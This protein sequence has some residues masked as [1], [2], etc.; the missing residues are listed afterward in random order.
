MSDLS[1]KNGDEDSVKSP[2]VGGQAGS[3]GTGAGTGSAGDAGS[4]KASGPGKGSETLESLKAKE[5]RVEKETLKNSRDVNRVKDELRKEKQFNSYSSWLGVINFALLIMLILGIYIYESS[6]SAR[7]KARL[8]DIKTGV[9]RLED[10]VQSLGEADKVTAISIQNIA[11]QAQEHDDRLAESDRKMVRIQGRVDALAGKLDS[12]QPAEERKVVKVMPPEKLLINEVRYLLKLSYRKMYLEH[13]ISVAVS[14]LRDADLLLAEMDDPEILPV[15]KGIAA[16]I[17]KLS[18]LEP[19][20]SESLVIRIAALEENVRSMPVLG[21]KVNFA[22]AR[23]EAGQEDGGEVSDDISDWKD[24]L[25]GSMNRFFGS[26]MVIK[27]NEGGR[28]QFL[29]ADEVAIL[30]DKITLILMQAQL[31]V[32]SQQQTSYEQNLAKA[33]SLVEEFCDREDFTTVQVLNEIHALQSQ[34]VIFIGIQQF[35]SLNALRDYVRKSADA[36]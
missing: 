29:S 20:D 13:D 24:N 11:S 35:D 16:D 9:L 30:Q 3:P 36:R 15:R 27:K 2:S 28:H 18:A 7:T 12:F 31:A 33:A 1:R 14:L 26:L 21:Y 25:A 6:F 10:R 32:Y 22:P 19:V 17:S 4:G 5:N 34:S 23:D 8:Y